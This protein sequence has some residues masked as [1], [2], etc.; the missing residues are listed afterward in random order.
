MDGEE[1]VRMKSLIE[2]LSTFCDGVCLNSYD[3]AKK[4]FNDGMMPDGNKWAKKPVPKLGFDNAPMISK[5]KK[6]DVGGIIEYQFKLDLG[7]GRGGGGGIGVDTSMTNQLINL[8]G[9]KKEVIDNV[10][11]AFEDFVKKYKR[12]LNASLADWMKK[13]DFVWGFLKENPRNFIVDDIMLRNVEYK[14][15]MI[16]PSRRKWPAGRTEIWMPITAEVIMKVR[17]K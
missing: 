10:S 13:E 4:A 3:A 17:R 16:D 6:K 9:T 14:A 11:M 15:P 8:L 12:K 5:V 2:Q 7:P 1:E